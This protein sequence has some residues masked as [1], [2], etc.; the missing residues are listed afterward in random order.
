MWGSMRAAAKGVSRARLGAGTPRGLPVGGARRQAVGLGAA[1]GTLVSPLW[2]S[3]WARALSSLLVSTPQLPSKALAPE[4]EDEDEEDDSEDAIS[5]FDFLGSGEDGEGPHDPRRCAAEG[6]HHELGELGRLGPPSSPR[7]PPLPAPAAASCPR[8]PTGRIRFLRGEWPCRAGGCTAVARPCP[9]P[10]RISEG[11]RQARLFLRQSLQ[12]S[13]PGRIGRGGGTGC[14]PSV[15]E[16]GGQRF[17]SCDSE[18]RGPR[19]HVGW[20]GI[21]AMEGPLSICL[22]LLSPTPTRSPGLSSPPTVA[23]EH[24]PHVAEWPVS[25]THPPAPCACRKPAGQTSGDLG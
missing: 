12:T 19:G 7:A 14:R 23:G 20:Q 3:K 16:A 2:A 10:W 11:H 1:G 22:L 6:A 13:S 17:L 15:G 8:V 5:E 25:D 24:P 9:L 18:L 4:T 21:E